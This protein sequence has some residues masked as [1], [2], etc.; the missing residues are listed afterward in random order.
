MNDSNA[1]KAEVDV[2]SAVQTD[3]CEHHWLIEPP[4]GPTSNGVCRVC[5]EERSFENYHFSTA[6]RQ[7]GSST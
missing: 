5:G 4:S 7:W 6:A 1:Q 2:A 3:Q